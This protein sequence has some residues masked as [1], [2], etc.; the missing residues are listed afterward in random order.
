MLTPFCDALALRRSKANQYNHTAL[1]KIA[2]VNSKPETDFYLGKKI[3]FIYKAKTEK[4]GSLYRV[5]WGKVRSGGRRHGRWGAAA[6]E[7]RR[8]RWWRWI[9]AAGSDEKL[10]TQPHDLAQSWDCAGSCAC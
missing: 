6:V 8:E 10:G 7:Q 3:A 5:I 9:T 1:I 4:K 2:G